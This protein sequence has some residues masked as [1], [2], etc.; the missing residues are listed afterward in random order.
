[1][2]MVNRKKVGLALGGGG[3]K[4]LAHV[5]VLK[6]LEKYNIPIDYISGTSMGAF[7]GALYSAGPNAKK[8]EKDMIKTNWNELFDYT[9]PIQGLLKGEKIENF[10]KKKI[11]NKEFKDVTSS[12][13]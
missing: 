10:L 3:A 7:V 2:I 12:V 6:V 13:P 8:L 1:M 4:G 11:E 5:G 9:I